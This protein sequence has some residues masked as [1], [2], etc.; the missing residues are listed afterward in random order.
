MGVP[1]VFSMDKFVIVIGRLVAFTI[2]QLK[3]CVDRLLHDPF[4]YIDFK[5]HVV[6]DALPPGDLVILVIRPV[7]I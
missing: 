1:T 2:Y 4:L 7:A 6:C 5:V 3:S